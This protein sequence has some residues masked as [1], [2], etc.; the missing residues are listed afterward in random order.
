MK[1]IGVYVGSFNPVHRGHIRIAR[2]CLKQKL[3]D[4]VLIIATGAYW[5][6]NDLLPLEERIGMLEL[7]KEPGMVVDRRYNDY[8]Y[9]YQIFKQ[10]EKDY[11]D[12]SFSLIIGADNLPRFNEWQEYKTLLKYDFLVVRRRG[13]DI[14]ENMSRL[15]KTNYTVLDLEEMPISSTFIREHLDDYED[16]RDML[17]RRV[18]DYLKGNVNMQHEITERH[19]LLD[20]NGHLIETGYAKSL[21]LDYDRKAIKAPSLRIKEWDYYLVYNDRFG[22]AL[23]VDDNSYM[24]LDSISLLDFRIPWEHTNSPMKVMTL[25]KRNFPSSSKEGNVKG[26]GKGYSIEFLKE[27]G[28]RILNFRMEDFCEGKPIEGSITLTDPDEESMVIVTPYKESKVHFYYNQK[29]NCMPAEGK[30]VYDGKEYVFD[31]EDS[32]GTLDW[33]RGVWTYKNTWYWGSASGLVD[34]HRFGFNIGYGFGDTSAA[35][36]NMLFWDGKAHKL[37]RVTFNIPQKDGKDDFL[38]PWTFTSDDGR[39]E[40]DFKPVMDRAANTDFIILGSNQHQVFGRFSGT[41]VLD[42][43]E[44]IE[45]RDLLGFA[46][47]VANKW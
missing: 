39:F 5:Q 21:I 28:K 38:S 14:K 25:G 6:K 42:D 46:E 33:G 36:E 43:G 13:T 35:S 31:K 4:E 10:L 11:E 15:N 2:E 1:K 19:P 16:V 29:I 24:A 23:T 45:I 3:V 30:V 47:K 34:G 20:E 9:T 32:F 37:S 12:T 7:V 40:M 22:V 17:D 26:D 18:Y 41:C 8:P 27:K 44:K